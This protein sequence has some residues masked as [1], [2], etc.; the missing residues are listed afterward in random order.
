LAGDEP[1]RLVVRPGLTFVH[2]AGV[3]TTLRYVGQF[4]N[5]FQSNAIFGEV[6][7]QF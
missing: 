3:S 1:E 6:R 5:N 2:P 4:Q 7:V